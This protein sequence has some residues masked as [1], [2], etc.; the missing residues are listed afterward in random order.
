MPLTYYPRTDA[1]G[2]DVMTDG[3]PPVGL[4]SLVP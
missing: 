2:G 3:K 1:S 4:G